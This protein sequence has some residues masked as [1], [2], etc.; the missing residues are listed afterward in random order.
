MY[1]Y[2]YTS[3]CILIP[4]RNQQKQVKQPTSCAFLT[5][6]ERPWPQP[7]KHWKE[8]GG[9]LTGSPRDSQV[10]S[11][12][13][14]SP[15]ISTPHLR[16]NN[17]DKL[18]VLV[19]FCL[20]IRFLKSVQQPEFLHSTRWNSVF[21]WSGDKSDLVRGGDCSFSGDTTSTAAGGGGGVTC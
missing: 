10:F 5:L 2:I 19:C 4:S 7:L 12:W 14:V 3:Y 16:G 8:E 11:S 21:P 15:Q 6:T 18:L 1:S 17:Q 13:L 20:S 9:G